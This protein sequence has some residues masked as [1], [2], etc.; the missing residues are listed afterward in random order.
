MT[1]CLLTAAAAFSSCSSD[2]VIDNGG[3]VID[4]TAQTITLAVANAGDNFLATRA[5][6][7]LYSSAAQQ[8]IDKVKV[9]IYQLQNSLPTGVTTNA[10]LTPTVLND[11]PLYGNNK[12]IVAQKVFSPWMNNGVS[13]VYSASDTG[14]GRLASWTLSA[15]DQILEEGVYMAY[16]V[17]YNDSEYAAITSFND[18]A[19]SG[20]FTFP[21]SIAQNTVDTGVAPVYEVFAGCTPF[22]VTKKQVKDSS[23]Y[24]YHFNVSLTL[25]RQVAGTIGYFT[26]I[27]VK[28]NADHESQT[29][30][31]L[32]LVAS[33]KSSNVVF[34]GFNSTYKG[35]AGVPATSTDA[36][37]K[38]VVNGYNSSSAPTCDAK[39][40]GTTGDNDAYTVY[41]VTLSN[42]FTDNGTNGMDTDGDGMLNASDKW[43]NPLDET[44]NNT[45]PGVTKGCVLG[46]SFLF[47]FAMIADK[48]TLQLQMLDASGD[49]IRYWSIRLQ[50]SSSSTDTQIGKTATLVKSDGTTPSNTD[51]ENFA[52]YSIL[53]NHLYSI[54]L[55]NA[56]DGGTDTGGDDKATS[57]N[58][59]TLILRVNDNWE[60][61]HSMDID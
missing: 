21:L 11:I 33:G 25:H 43:T 28:G 42:W 19:K 18:V 8:N 7:S 51:T 32:R 49:I 36:T 47:P 50:N 12:T 15:D 58:D 14:N 54:G 3:I 22:V 34:A 61:I 6:R 9:V 57:L 38:Y 1:A 27:P 45:N 46:S 23:D 39:F 17:G 13:N 56:G 31:K 53:R 40:Y 41:E 10:D 37:V 44:G 30:A 20:T 24:T 4:E 52:N 35:G 60:M 59:Q 16:A 26:N 5:A 48:P 29:G 2:D 55:R